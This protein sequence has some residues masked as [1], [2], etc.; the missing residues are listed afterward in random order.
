MTARWVVLWWRMQA[1]YRSQQT[2]LIDLLPFSSR[3]VPPTVCID[4]IWSTRQNLQNHDNWPCLAAAASIKKAQFSEPQVGRQQCTRQ[5]VS[6]FL[7]M[8]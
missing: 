4:V 1:Y 2:S 5:V 6:N 7:F 8:L 3:L